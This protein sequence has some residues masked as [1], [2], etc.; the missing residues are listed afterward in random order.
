MPHDFLSSD[1]FTWVVLPALIFCARIVDVSMGTVRVILISRGIRLVAACIGFFEVL[2]WLVA[3]V[4]IMQRLSN[5]I[6]Y[7]AYAAGFATGTYVGMLVEARLRIGKAVIR[8]I[9]NKEAQGLIERLREMHCGVTALAAEGAVGPVKVIFSVIER[10]DQ[11]KVI[12]IIKE[13]DPCAF[14]TIGDVKYV[15]EGGFPERAPGL[16]LTRT[17]RK[18]K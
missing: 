17:V 4:Q 14:Y 11:E 9:T 13:F 2:I 12:A 1:L 15:S 6:C 3:I 18:G 7:L 8:T 5:P 10:R 16:T